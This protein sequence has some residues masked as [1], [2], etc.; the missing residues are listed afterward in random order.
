MNKGYFVNSGA[1]LL[2]VN[3][4]EKGAL[5]ISGW[6]ITDCGPAYLLGSNTLL[7]MFGLVGMGEIVQVGK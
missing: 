3:F 7:I 2:P 5:W 1:V 4:V 6:E